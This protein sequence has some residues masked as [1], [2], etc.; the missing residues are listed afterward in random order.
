[1][2]RTPTPILPLALLVLLVL[3]ANA[4]SPGEGELEVR[5]Y[6]E[7][8]IE[9]GI[10]ADM[11]SDGW[12]IEFSRFEVTLRDISIAGAAL[13]DPAPIDLVE[14]SAGE[15]QLIGRVAVRAGDHDDLEF[16]LVTLSL[17][18]SASKAG[19][20]KTF[21]WEFDVDLQF[22]ACET[23]TT[24]AADGLGS[25]EITIHAD[26]LFYDS[27]VAEAPALRFDA[28]AAADGDADG[29]ITRDELA[30]TDIGAY[31]PGNLPIDDLWAFLVAQAATTAHVDGEG[32][33]APLEG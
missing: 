33:C 31:D 18:G 10:P 8:F 29:V 5:T 15:G 27:L 21:A 1:M 22:G 12:A 16:T 14:P 9:Q 3:V 17:D 20:T 32:H 2:I 28:I 13:P 4:C 19:V 11:M 30:A 26:H 24:V 6:G 7:E 25:V 23:T